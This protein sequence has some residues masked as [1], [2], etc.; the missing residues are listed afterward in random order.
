MSRQCPCERSTDGGPELVCRKV[1]HMRSDQ[2]A[3]H[4]NAEFDN[5]GRS[6]E[7]KTDQVGLYYYLIALFR[8][9]RIEDDDIAVLK[10]KPHC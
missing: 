6:L 7:N 3:G 10:I 8:M 9:N 1:Q 4:G 2:H 5:G